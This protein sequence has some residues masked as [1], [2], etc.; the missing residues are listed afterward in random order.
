MS[1]DE[2]VIVA[3]GSNLG[4]PRENVLLGIE[5][6]R[7]FS[8]QPLLVSCLMP[9]RPVDCPSGSPDFINAAVA[10]IPRPDETPERLLRELQAIEQAFGRKPKL[11]LNEPRPLDL[12]LIAFQREVRNT[13]EL[14][15]PHPRAVQR[16]FVLRPLAELAPDLILPGQQLTVRE[17]LSRIS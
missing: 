4:D 14:T 10:F 11:V 9:S 12:D 7:R 1:S 17:L 8:D 2:L 6:L 15:L 3:L 13:P 16:A 5:A